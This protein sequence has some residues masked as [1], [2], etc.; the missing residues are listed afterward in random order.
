MKSAPLCKRMDAALRLHVAVFWVRSKPT[1]LC[2][3]RRRDAHPPLDVLLRAVDDGDVA[4]AQGEDLV[5]QH[6]QRVGATVHD[7]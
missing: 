5:A 7:V 2:P 1:L 4:E 3:P 6:G